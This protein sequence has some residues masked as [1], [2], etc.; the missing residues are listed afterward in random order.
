MLPDILGQPFANKHIKLKLDGKV[1]KRLIAEGREALPYEYSALLAGRGATIT[2]HFAN[3][4]ETAATETFS[5]SGP[6]L[7]TTLQLLRERELRWLGCVH[8]HPR[9]PAIPSA[10]DH[11]GWHYPELS[12]WIL[13]LARP[14][15]PELK[16]YQMAGGRFFAREFKITDEGS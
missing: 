2:C 15:Q 8:T 10:A 12:Y 6:A 11:A 16:L 7:L 5:W 13:S 14:D 9:T 4:S 1:L 3:V